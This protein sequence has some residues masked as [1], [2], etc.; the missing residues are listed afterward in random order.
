MRNKETA[1]HVL[2]E[3]CGNHAPRGE[4]KAPSFPHESYKSWRTEARL[5]AAAVS[6][7]PWLSSEHGGPLRPKNAAWRD[8]ESRPSPVAALRKALTQR[9][10]LH[11]L[12]SH[13]LVGLYGCEFYWGRDFGGRHLGG[14]FQSKYN[15]P[16]RLR[17]GQGSRASQNP[18]PPPMDNIGWVSPEGPSVSSPHWRPVPNL[19]VWPKRSGRQLRAL[20]GRLLHRPRSEVKP[21]DLGEQHSDIQKQGET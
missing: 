4:T 5:A 20:K 13:F 9:L 11:I 8:C 18:V 14:S 7:T 16:G 1:S 3:I 6:C 15:C 10:V 2:L 19:S 17:S 12:V 21:T